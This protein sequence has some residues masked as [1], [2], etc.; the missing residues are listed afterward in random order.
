[1][2]SGQEM[3]DI[4]RRAEREG[5]AIGEW[6][7]RVL[8]KART[9]RPVIDPKTKLA[10]VRLAVKHSFPKSDIDRMLREIERGYGE[11]AIQDSCF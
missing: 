9:A 7:R 2:L 3:S 4:Q 5:L 8:L 11:G 1:M 6:V 10:A